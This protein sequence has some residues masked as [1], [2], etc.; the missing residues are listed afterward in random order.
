MPG[1]SGYQ[2]IGYLEQHS[3]GFP[4]GRGPRLERLAHCSP[5]LGPFRFSGFRVSSRGQI[6]D[7]TSR[8]T[9]TCYLES[10]AAGMPAATI[11][12]AAWEILPTGPV[13]APRDFP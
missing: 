2:T 5:S 4:R 13:Q 1:L 7:T 6:W 8:V 3:R 10:I 9:P 12:L 11:E